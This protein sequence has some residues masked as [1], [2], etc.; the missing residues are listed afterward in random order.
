MS[1]AKGSL[2][3][4][5]AALFVLMLALSGCA[6]DSSGS[7]ADASSG[8]SDPG[9]G[10]DSKVSV[11]PDVQPEKGDGGQPAAACTWP[12]APAGVS[13]VLYVGIGC[14]STGA[15]GSRDRPFALI[16]EALAAVGEAAEAAILLA[17]GTQPEAVSVSTGRIH[18]LGAT[19]DSGTRLATIAGPGEGVAVRVGAGA[20][21]ILGPVRVAGGGEAGV[22]AGAGAYLEL[23]DSSIEG[24][25]GVGVLITEARGIILNNL[26][27]GNR[28]GGIRI[29]KAAEK[30]RVEGNT[31]RG[32]H[33]FGI[34]GSEAVGII[35][36]NL[37]KDTSVAVGDPGGALVA[38]GIQMLGPGG[39]LEL[40]DNTVQGSGRVG[41]LASGEVVGIIL[42]N[43]VSSN[44][45]AGIWLEAR[46]G[47]AGTIKV[48]GNTVRD[49][50]FVGIGMTGESVGIILNNLVSGT[51]P[52]EPEREGEVAMGDGI[53]VF[54]G[55]LCE[56][57]DN[58]ANGNARA[59][60]LVDDA[61][62]AT[63]VVGNNATGNGYGVVVQGQ[64]TQA[65]GSEP[66][67]SRD[68]NYEADNDH[69]GM[70]GGPGLPVASGDLGVE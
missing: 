62:P 40:R 55:S 68:E 34:S 33:R 69:V 36:N 47:K 6:A 28:G 5:G 61:H 60:I 70:S 23:R 24:N 42:N 56:V 35:L 53:G 44:G 3:G 20:E 59:A 67:G 13:L 2:K 25:V 26:V 48:E 37:I 17:P 27:A 32:N 18:I 29:E 8:G 21:L 64:L 39:N 31:V 10:E 43:K 57:R 14:A 46:A 9:Q 22:Q 45:R 52:G 51:A 38:D 41:V 58:D 50:G 7:S 4:L 49:N 19:D 30:V 66:D 63:V 1:V 65:T 54:G 12:G 16:S 11:G 15:D